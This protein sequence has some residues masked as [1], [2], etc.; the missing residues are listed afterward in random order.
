MSSAALAVDIF[1]MFWEFILSEP[2]MLPPANGSLVMSL[3]LV[4]PEPLPLMMLPAVRVKGPVI[5]PPVSGSLVLSKT[6]VSAAP[7]PVNVAAVTA[8]EL[9]MV[10]VER[11][12][13]FKLLNVMPP[14]TAKVPPTLRF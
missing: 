2:V 3:M 11:V 6:P 12:V 10:V 9:F 5:V 14:A 8:P 1:V 4:R 13:T 7:F